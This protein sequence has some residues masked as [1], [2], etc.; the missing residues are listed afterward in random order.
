[1]DQD[2]WPGSVLAC[3]DKMTPLL[4]RAGIQPLTPFWR[5]VVGAAYGDPDWAGA[6]AD[7]LFPL[8]AQ[9]GGYRQVVARV[10]RRGRKSY[11]WCIVA[12]AE[13]LSARHQIPPGDTGVIAIVSANTEQ[14]ADRLETVDAVLRA[15][16]LEEKA[17]YKR[18]AKGFE[19]VG[20]FAET[21][22][23]RISVLASSVK[24]VSSYTCIMAMGDE[25]AK[26]TDGDKQVNP[27]HAVIGSWRATMLT[28]RAAKM[29]LLS[30]PV[31]FED[32][33]A[34]AFDIGTNP[35]QLCVHAPTWV[36]NPTVSEADCRKDSLAEKNAERWFQQECAAV[37]QSGDED[38]GGITEEQVKRAT[39]PGIGPAP[40]LVYVAGLHLCKRTHEW[41]AMVC[42][43]RR[44]T[45]GQRRTSVLLAHSWPGDTDPRVL[46]RTLRAML[47]PYGGPVVWMPAGSYRDAVSVVQRRL[48]AA[49]DKDAPDHGSLRVRFAADGIELVAHPELRKDLLSTR[50]KVTATGETWEAQ[51]FSVLLAMLSGKATQEPDVPE[52][53]P[54]YGSSE[55]W[56]RIADEE[57]RQDLEPRQEEDWWGQMWREAGFSEPEPTR[58]GIPQPYSL[59]WHMRRRKGELLPH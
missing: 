6:E 46:A 10:G 58:R 14:A 41:A 36:A 44:C 37:P 22:P 48:T 54:V 4:E 40:G 26:W 13:I 31:G 32:A 5:A 21:R 3:I 23:Y 19:L 55:W 17:D 30:S 8:P 25:V 15:V 9:P 29:I 34:Q 18:T 51:R 59:D 7:G 28:Q 24:A 33:H 12:V 53:L 42:A 16:G 20:E 2:A 49:V 56:Q 57:R 39:K 27:A 52:E 43:R 45:D 38:G 1:M 11:T 47:E 50:R 35:H